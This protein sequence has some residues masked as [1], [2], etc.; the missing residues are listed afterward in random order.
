MAASEFFI[1]KS[2][3]QKFE[4]RMRLR[5]AEDISRARTIRVL[6]HWNLLVF[7]VLALAAGFLAAGR[8]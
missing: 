7:R 8:R 4:Q 6:A 2:A 1:S 5:V 3:R